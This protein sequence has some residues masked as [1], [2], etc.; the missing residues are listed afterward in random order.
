M[1]DEKVRHMVREAVREA[2]SGSKTAADNDKKESPQ[3]YF[4]PWTGVEYEAHPSRS[5][6]NVAEAMLNA[7]D[8]AEFI[9]STVCSIEKNKSCDNCG[10]CRSLG[11]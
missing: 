1:V 9:E 6:F 7:G 5:Q 2:L 4:A 3:S 8:V 10:M 11:F